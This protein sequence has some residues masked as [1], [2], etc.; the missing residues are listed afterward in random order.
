MNHAQTAAHS[1]H[2]RMVITSLVHCDIYVRAWGH[3]TKR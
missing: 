3:A 2:D 1:L